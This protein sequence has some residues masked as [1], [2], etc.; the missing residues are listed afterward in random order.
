MRVSSKKTS[1]KKYATSHKY[2]SHIPRAM[3]FVHDVKNISSM[4]TAFHAKSVVVKDF[5]ADTFHSYGIS[6]RE[7]KASGEGW[8]IDAYSVGAP[9]KT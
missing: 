9:T 6:R 7:Y 3:S 1:L 8:M 4:F 2:E 5:T